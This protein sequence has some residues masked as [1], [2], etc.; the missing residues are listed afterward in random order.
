[1]RL[2]RIARISLISFIV[3]TCLALA[4][5]Y[6]APPAL[7]WYARREFAARNFAGAEKALRWVV[8]IEPKH[9]DAHFL[10]AQDLRHMARYPEADAELGLAV[11][12]GLTRDEGLREFGLLWAG[13]DFSKAEGALQHVLEKRPDDVEVLKALSQGCMRELR[14]NQAEVYLTRWLQLRPDQVEPLLERGR[15]YLDTRQFAKAITDFRAL[16]KFSPEN[17]RAHLWLGLALLSDARI[18]EAEPELKLARQMRPDSAEPLICLAE[19]AR[20]KGDINSA[21]TLL[22]D[23]LGLDPGSLMA[24]RDL[25]ELHMSQRRFE[26]AAEIWNR[27]LRDN[28]GDKL[29]HLK[30]AQVL[31]KLGKHEDAR[32]HEQR[33]KELDA[34][35]A[36][37]LKI[38]NDR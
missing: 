11:D 36:Q 16:L 3:L 32:K 9:R 6:A 19:C 31:E 12:F 20:E 18:N 8:A 35:E 33:Y 7:M 23:A 28:P 17:Y 2:K 5:L 27:I 29:A 15:L 37:Q 4:G 10:Y 21:Y 34:R 24:L 1:M 25:G 30:L 22:Y 38:R 14:A 26:D 13:F